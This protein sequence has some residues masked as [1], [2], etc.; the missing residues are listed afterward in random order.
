[1]E[2]E[3]LLED[4]QG[5]VAEEFDNSGPLLLDCDLERGQV[6]LQMIKYRKVNS[7]LSCLLFREWNGYICSN[8]QGGNFASSEGTSVKSYGDLIIDRNKS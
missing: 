6:L 7:V 5:R 1:M 4:D 3:G 2:V 8:V